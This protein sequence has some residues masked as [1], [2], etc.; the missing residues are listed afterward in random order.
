MTRLVWGEMDRGRVAAA[1]RGG[2]AVALAVGAV[3]QHGPHLPTGT[4]ILVAQ[5]ITERAAAAAVRPVLVLP[6]MPFGLSHYHRRWGAT[7]SLGA[8][9]LTRV[10]ADVAASVAAAGGSDLFIVNGHGGNRGICTTIGLDMSTPGFRVIGLCYWDVAT[11]LAKAHFPGDH[12][13]L[14]HAG[15]AETAI[16]AS[17]FPALARPGPVPHEPIASALGLTALQRLGESGVSGD[18]AAAREEQGG[19][20]VDAVVTRLAALFDGVASAP[21]QAA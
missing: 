19:A 7:I 18:P 1:L 9:T 3:E 10:L 5:E 6:G 15:E 20:F 14:G 11:D 16:V 21:G 17:L 13:S 4:D 8:E 12:G 2:A